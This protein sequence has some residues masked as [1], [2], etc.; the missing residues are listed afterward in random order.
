MRLMRLGLQ[1]FLSEDLIASSSFAWPRFGG[2]F[3]VARRWGEIR[4]L[5]KA[6]YVALAMTHRDFGGRSDFR[7]YGRWSYPWRSE[8]DWRPITA[9]VVLFI[10]LSGLIVYSAI[11]L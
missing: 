1:D 11:H 3:L 2:A 5:G 8:D 7:H 6:Q 10:I 4:E 9:A